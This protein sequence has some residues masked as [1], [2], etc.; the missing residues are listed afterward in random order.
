MKQALMLMGQRSID[1]LQEFGY[2]V[3]LSAEIMYWLLLGKLQ[4]QSVRMDTVVVEAMQIGVNAILIASLLCFAVG[5]MLAIQG[6]ETLKVFGAESQ[7]ILGITLSV[8]REFSPLIVGILVAGRSGS[9]IAARVGSMMESQEIDALRVMGINPVRFLA[10]PIFLAMLIMLPLLTV[11]GDL[12]GL[13]GGAVFTSLELHM[14]LYAYALRTLDIMSAD[15]LFQGL[16]KSTVFAFLI[17]VVSLS[18]GFQARGGA[19]GIGR[20]T[21]RAVVMSISCII[22]ADMMFTYLLNH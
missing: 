2:G 14:S 1:A 9:A 3:A 22:L 20:V 5:V 19:E 6:I 13:L 8:T 15:D 4:K 18:N 12:M 7:V 10:A 21:T 16:V 11:L 17:A